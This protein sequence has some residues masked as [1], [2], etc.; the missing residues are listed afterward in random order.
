MSKSTKFL[1]KIHLRNGLF[2][3]EE[4]VILSLNIFCDKTLVVSFYFTNFLLNTVAWNTANAYLEF[5]N[6]AD[7]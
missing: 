4:K 3:V 6:L 7:R 1:Q 2:S 5:L